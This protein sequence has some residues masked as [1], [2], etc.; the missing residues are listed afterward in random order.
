MFLGDNLSTALSVAKDCD[1]VTPDQ[2]I[3]TVNCDDKIPPNIYYSLASTRN[4]LPKNDSNNNN[5]NPPI[6]TNG[7]SLETVENQHSNSASNNFR[8]ALTGKVWA[9]IRNHYPELL[10][11]ICT[12]GEYQICN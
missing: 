3:I 10:P 7:K 11:R 2:N 9:M 6:Y 5:G 12:R 4:K 1:I 8:F